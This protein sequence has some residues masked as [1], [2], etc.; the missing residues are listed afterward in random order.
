MSS[1]VA[2]VVGDAAA[3][4][5]NDLAKRSTHRNLNKTGV[6]DFAADGENLSTGRFFRADASEPVST[7]QNNFRDIGVRL[8]VIENRRLAED[9][10]NSRERRTRTRFAALA[11]DGS[12]ERRFLAAD[13]SAG[14]ESYF[15]I[16]IK[17][18]AENIFAE[19]AVFLRLINSEL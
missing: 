17:A 3:D 2:L 19:Q 9:A 1:F 7:V 5:E 11:F 15:Y 4:V 13:E 16:K 8:D 10:L 6:F 18:C 14:A 12:H